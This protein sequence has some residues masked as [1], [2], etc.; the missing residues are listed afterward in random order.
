MSILAKLAFSGTVKHFDLFQRSFECTVAT[1]L[2][3]F[4]KRR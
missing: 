3:D 2:K 4:H 1:E